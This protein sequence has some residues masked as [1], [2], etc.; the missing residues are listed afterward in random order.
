M[1][2]T[3]SPSSPIPPSQDVNQ[4][5]QDLN[6]P[7]NHSPSQSPSNITITP[8]QLDTLL[9]II[10]HQQAATPQSVL[11]SVA[12]SR[13]SSSSLPDFHSLAKYEEIIT[14]PICPAYD[15]LPDGLIPFLNRLDIRRQDES[16]Y[17]IT[18]LTV[19]Q[20]SYDLLRHFTEVSEAAVLA[21]AKSRWFSPTLQQDKFQITHQMYQACV[22]A[23]LL[24]ASLTDDFS[25]TIIHR[26][27]SSYRNDGVVILWTIC[28]NVH[29]SNIAFTE[30]IKA[31]IR[32]MNLMD[33]DTID[34]YLI[35]IKDNLRLITTSDTSNKTKHND[36]IIYIFNHLKQCTVTPFKQYISRL[37]VQYLE[38]SLPDLTPVSLLQMAEDKIQVLRHADQWVKHEDPSLMALQAQLL[39]QKEDSHRTIQRLV[40]HVS[41]LA[42]R[43]PKRGHFDSNTAPSS[44]Y[45]AWMIQPPAVGQHTQLM[46]NRLYTW[47]TK[48]RQGQG[49]WVCRHNTDTHVDGYVPQ[50][51]VR[52]RLS[53]HTPTAPRADSYRSPPSQPHGMLTQSPPSLP[54][55]PPPVTAQ[56]SILDYLDAYCDPEQATDESN[57]YFDTTEYSE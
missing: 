37:Q 21:D 10:R 30:T 6:D 56:L 44:R 28:H 23:K 47:C 16:W 3:T 9:R 36:L 35:S 42:Q 33:Y 50:R 51:Q 25:I 12:G 48:C 45:P 4:L 24:L 53:G 18:F 54:V 26:I 38:A 22:L 31:K 5:L 39:Q 20:K 41:R 29:R 2:H 15:G 11:P 7:G 40:A 19:Q 1:S 32:G 55:P 57:N 13:L 27:D 14:K 17:P 49:L 43:H 46:D 52:R 34:K 8:G